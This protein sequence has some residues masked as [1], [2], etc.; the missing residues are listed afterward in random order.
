MRP[1][2][3][4]AEAETHQRAL[5]ADL[6]VIRPLI[7]GN[8]VFFDGP[9]PTGTAKSDERTVWLHLTGSQVSSGYFIRRTLDKGRP[10]A[11]S[12]LDFVIS[13]Q[14]HAHATPTPGNRVAFL[15]RAADYL[16][17]YRPVMAGEPAARSIFDVHLNG[18][19]LLYTRAPCAPADVRES[20]PFLLQL[21]PARASDLPEG[22]QQYGYGNHDFRFEQRGAIIDGV[23]F[24]RIELPEYEI[25][26]LR[27]GQYTPGQGR[28]WGR[29]FPFPPLPG[30]A[31]ARLKRPGGCRWAAFSRLRRRPGGGRRIGG[32]R[33]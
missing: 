30:R 23:C 3:P 13:Y 2:A 20:L 16:D 1:A 6:E 4:A 21:Y 5:I 12:D 26:R 10:I 7:S 14:R 29:S 18:S 28:C 31:L 24:A 17:I 27:T 25:V 15:Y 11:V 9:P 33:R 8:S 22:R 19:E 32:G